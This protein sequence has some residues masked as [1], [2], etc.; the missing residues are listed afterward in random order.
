MASAVE[1]VFIAYGNGVV[2]SICILNYN[3]R[4]FLDKG[5]CLKCH[6]FLSLPL[7]SEHI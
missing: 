7:F 1:N 2:D 4:C 6:L 5:L 3:L